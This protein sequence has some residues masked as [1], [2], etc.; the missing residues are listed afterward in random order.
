MD[1]YVVNT[2]CTAIP[3]LALI[4]GRIVLEPF[5]QSL[6]SE[7]SG[8]LLNFNCKVIFHRST[9]MD[10]SYRQ[11]C[12][13]NTICWI[14]MKRCMHICRDDVTSPVKFQGQKTRSKK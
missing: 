6:F 1:I 10:T 8:D 3:S 12:D 7:M 2:L 14:I 9:S 13:I 11:D 5:V 4:V